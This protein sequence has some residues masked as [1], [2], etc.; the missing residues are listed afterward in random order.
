MPFF[1]SPNEDARV[2]V[3]PQLREEGRVYEEFVVG[4]Y[5]QKRLEVDR[6]TH[7]EE[8]EGRRGVY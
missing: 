7:L 6:T 2:S 5:F 1:F 4:E 8:G 3:V